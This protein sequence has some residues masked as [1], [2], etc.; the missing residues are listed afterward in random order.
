M[1]GSVVLVLALLAASAHADDST[2][3]A[4][5]APDSGADELTP[6]EDIGPVLLI[7]AIEIHGNTS[8]QSE[9]I[10]RALPIAP[11]D[12]LRASDKRLRSARFRVLALGYFREVTLAMKKGSERGNVV[13]DINVVERGTIVLNRLWFGHTNV[14]PYWLGADA[15]ERNLFG[16]GVG[17]GGGFIFAGKGDIENTRNQWAAEIRLAD[18]SLRGSPW[19]AEGSFTVVRG[20]D[21]Y[22]IGGEPTDDADANYR[23]FSYS[24][25]GGRFGMTYDLTALS[26]LSAM[27]RLE[28]IDAELPTA[29]TRVL[30]DG[31]V[32]PVD[33]HLEPGDSRIVTAGFGFDRDTRPDPVLPHT[34]G[35]ITLAVELGTSALASD[36]DFATL[37][38]RFEHWWPLREERH[39]IG[40]R[41]AGGVV[42][43][44]APRFDRIHVADVDRMLTPRALGLVL[45][46]AA[47]LALLGT[48][49]DKPTFGDLGGSATV[50]YVWRIFRGIGISKRIYGGDLFL[51]AGI[52]GL[53][54]RSDFV[55]RDT[56]V[57]DALPIDLYLDGGLRIDTDIGIFELTVANALGRLR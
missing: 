51:G 22:R 52:W 31:R 26:R 54:E 25:I 41:L 13:I 44:N 1:R 14:A 27:I 37:F 15:A 53:A 38:A 20:S 5:P 19:G 4:E 9:L 29:P 35:R 24:R 23:G 39:S 43:G 28:T 21:V 8:T 40:V 42:V 30:P 10:R 47:P 55:Y 3:P 56:K 45:S 49:A 6:G 33:L 36:Y 57:W 48:R 16:L 32:V 11:G 2:E 50:E 18:G 12:V 7:E 34:G 17:V 46:N